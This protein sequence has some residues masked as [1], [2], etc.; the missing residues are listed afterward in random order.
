MANATEWGLIGA[1]S[2]GGEL[3]RQLNQDYVAERLEMNQL[4]SFVMR[5]TG[6]M[7]PDGKSPLGPKSLEDIDDFPEVVFLAIPSSDD[8]N[9][10]KGYIDTVLER[11]KIA[12]TAEKGAIANHFEELK[13]SSDQFARFGINA[14]VGGG[15]RVLEIARTYCDD[16]DN[17]SQI[18][19]AV[20]GTLAAIMSSIAPPG[21]DGMSLG[22]A[23]HQA[24]ELGYAEPNAKTSYDVIKGEAEGDIPKKTAIFFNKLGLTKEL[25]DWD[26][27]KFNL[28]DEE[29][30]QAIE[31]AETRRFIVSLYSPMHLV[32]NPKGPEEGKIG[33]FDIEHE[34]WR[35]VGGFRHIKRNP[36]F[37][38]IAS[39]TGP[40][41][42]LVIGL[43]PDETDGVFALTGP[44]A[45]V[46]TTANTM[47]DDFVAR[48]HRA[49]LY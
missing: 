11:G 33:G 46:N 34:G 39:S 45:G 36:L 21:G 15:T 12:V 6:L 29:I 24:V 41:N 1:G 3:A 7:G 31:E 4:P 32:K 9:V 13:E 23:V 38:R 37:S 42:G 10:A 18:H 48:T 47:I 40:S 30:G 2:V 5:S 49:T 14:T 27:L 25:I 20:N 22:Q 28:T 8:G 35:V 17:I 44:G 26:E 43:G 16:I 19:L